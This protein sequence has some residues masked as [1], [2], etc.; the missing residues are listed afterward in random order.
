MNTGVTITSWGELAILEK[1]LD[2]Y[3]LHAATRYEPMATHARSLL[4]RVRPAL[5]EA[6][7]NLP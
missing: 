4:K 5:I 1:L 6:T 3:T 2:D 7:N